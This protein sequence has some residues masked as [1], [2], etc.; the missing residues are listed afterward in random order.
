[1]A[2]IPEMNAA[3]SPLCLLYIKTLI[4]AMEKARPGHYGS[5]GQK[6]R[7]GLRQHMALMDVCMLICSAEVNAEEETVD[8][9][10]WYPNHAAKIAG[11]P[12]VADRTIPPGEIWFVDEDGIPAGKITGL[13]EPVEYK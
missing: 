9:L 3:F 1:M 2:D 7:M 5:G 4:D 10:A 8:P 11:V 6:W 13:L 12:V